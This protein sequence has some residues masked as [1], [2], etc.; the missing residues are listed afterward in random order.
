MEMNTRLTDAT[1][2][3]VGPLLAYARMLEAAAE[4][5]T[6]TVR[7]GNGTDPF[8]H[9]DPRYIQQTLPALRLASE[10][11]FRADVRGLEKI[12]AQGPALLVGNHSGGT[13]I[14]HTFVFA[15][16]FYDH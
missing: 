16:K 4:D 13:M 5:V 8:A 6:E 11:Y 12:P 7:G 10:L 2:N 3:V 9:R 1:V 15:Q 14:A